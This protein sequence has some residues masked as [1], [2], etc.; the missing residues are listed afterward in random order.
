MTSHSCRL[1]VLPHAG[2]EALPQTAV[3]TLVPLVLVHDAVAVEAARVQ[4]VLAHA[5]STR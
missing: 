2:A 3:A 1:T 4:V 5:A